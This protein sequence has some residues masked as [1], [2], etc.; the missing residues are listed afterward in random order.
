MNE[1]T[2]SKREILEHL[3]KSENIVV[4]GLGKLFEDHFMTEYEELL[5][6]VTCFTDND[7][8]YWG[9]I[10]CGKPVYSPS[11][12]HGKPKLC[13]I[14]FVS[15]P[16]LSEIKD[17]IRINYHIDSVL[18]M[19]DLRLLFYFDSERTLL[20]LKRIRPVSISTKGHSKYSLISLIINQGMSECLLESKENPG[21]YFQLSDLYGN[22]SSSLEKNQEMLLLDNNIFS[23]SR[24]LLKRNGK[25]LFV[26]VFDSEGNIYVVYEDRTDWLLNF[27]LN[28][29]LDTIIEEDKTEVFEELEG[30]DILFNECNEFTYKL[31]IAMRKKLNQ[32]NVQ[33]HFVTPEWKSILCDNNI[34]VKENPSQ[35]ISDKSNNFLYFKDLPEVPIIADTYRQLLVVAEQW[36]SRHVVEAFS[37]LRDLGICTHIFN[38]PARSDL[39]YFY[40]EEQYAYEHG[41]SLDWITSKKFS[42][43]D[44]KCMEDI[45][46]DETVFAVRENK[47][48]TGRIIGQIE[49][50]GTYTTVKEKRDNTVYII[51]PCV[52]MQTDLRTDETIVSLLQKKLDQYFD[53]HFKVLS[54][55]TTTPRYPALD[56]IIQEL[57][58]YEGDIVFYIGYGFSE[59]FQNSMITDLKDIFLAR[60]RSFFSNIPVHVNGA[61]SQAIAANLFTYIQT[62]NLLKTSGGGVLNWASMLDS[63]VERELKHIY[64]SY[65]NDASPDVKIGAIVMNGNPFT[66]GHLHLIRYASKC[67]KR[68]YVFVV[69]ED[70]SIFPF[71]D[72]FRLIKEGTKDISNVTVLPSGKYVISSET[73]PEYFMKETLT[74][75][76][77]DTSRDLLIF[78][79]GIAPIFHINYR[80]VGEENTDTV[81]AQYNI[82]MKK[83]LPHYGINVV[84]IERKRL[85]EKEISASWVRECLDSG[86][87][88]MLKD[89]VPQTTFLYLKDRERKLK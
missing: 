88:E 60:P 8:Q 71:A 16:A 58:I 65:T 57:T 87:I 77:I 3:M 9:T 48:M 19:N 50:V 64:K 66:K 34:L 46:G 63:Q 13:V 15:E 62:K 49:Q 40:P 30:K 52:V 10:L 55:V 54:I 67:V 23:T 61:G 6:Y 5:E 75:V 80:F 26:P 17:Q 33:F 2:F 76:C 68:L 36:Q 69:E 37:S 32:W 22:E 28:Q 38:I 7:S 78:A 51:G 81:T 45:Y 86:N 73:F 83:L 21:K 89:I 20:R 31:Y 84:E 79:L 44:W 43:Q 27:Q 85:H 59:Y 11:W 70:K 82:E 53:C 1:K 56:R 12:L 72:R 35:D 24:D 39:D 29:L 42:L 14:V 25:K 74:D 18:T 47:A 4:F 41:L